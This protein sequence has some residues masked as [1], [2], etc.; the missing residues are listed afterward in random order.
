MR[1]GLGRG[2]DLTRALQ[3]C[4]AL[5]ELE[6]EARNREGVRRASVLISNLL[7]SHKRSGGR[8]LVAGR[9]FG[10]QRCTREGNLES[11]V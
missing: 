2:T 6:K 3:A 8:G 10:H 5:G 1:V 7:R 11:T 9:S 4:T